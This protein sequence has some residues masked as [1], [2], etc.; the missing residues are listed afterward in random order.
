MD[1]RV[2]CMWEY[3]QASVVLVAGTCNRTLKSARSWAR[4]TTSRRR[5]TL[6]IPTEK[7]VQ[8]QYIGVFLRSVPIEGS[9]VLLEE[10]SKAHTWMSVARYQMKVPSPRA[11]NQQTVGVGQTRLNYSYQQSQGNNTAPPRRC[12]M[13]IC[14]R[15]ENLYWR[16][17][18]GPCPMS[19]REW[20]FR[21]PSNSPI[22]ED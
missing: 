22:S 6:P 9:F 17:R 2:P 11:K 20:R 3:R 16:D 21:P 13:A 19:R 12:T 18:I 7:Q 15:K 4:T 1:F 10:I 8:R 14:P 5:R